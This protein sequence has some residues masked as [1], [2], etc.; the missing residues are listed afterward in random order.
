MCK[1]TQGDHPV[2]RRRAA[3]APPPWCEAPRRAVYFD[4]DGSVRACCAAR[5]AIGSVDEPQR[6]SL[7]AIWSGDEAR[8]LREAVQIGD[9][10]LGCEECG[11][12]AGTLGRSATLAHHFDRWDGPVGGAPVDLEFA[13][14]NTCNLRC[15]MCN[16]FLSSSIR[17]QREHLPPLPSAYDDRFFDELTPWLATARR[18]AF[19]GGEPF[20]ATEA[21]RVMDLLL[22]LGTEAEV[23]VTTNGTQ[24]SDRIERYVTGLRMSPII[25]VDAMDRS[26]LEAIRVGVDAEVLWRNIDRFEAAARSVGERITFSYCLMR[27]NWQELAPLLVEAERR[28]AYVHVSYVHQPSTAA[29]ARLSA[30]ELQRV[31]AGM[32]DQEASLHLAD[33]D[34]RRTWD[35]ARAW[36]RGCAAAP[37]FPPEVDP[38][39]GTA[40]AEAVPVAISPRPPIVA[41]VQ[42]TPTVPEHELD[43]L[44]RWSAGSVVLVW[45]ESGTIERAEVPPW[46]G[47][48]GPSLFVGRSTLD[49]AE[50]FAG[51]VG[52]V[53]TPDVVTDFS[54]VTRARLADE[55]GR[56]LI[57]ALGVQRWEREELHIGL[58]PSFRDEFERRSASA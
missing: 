22:E 19:K 17:A 39:A 10:S 23:K 43:E 42:D 53:L 33:P 57:Q 48:D 51:L 36:V 38:A 2:S 56:E 15:V 49:L 58:H 6:R 50:M 4:V 27:D 3:E 24:W 34:L 54:G 44:H 25:S 37:V 41:V 26:L 52:L 21:R 30:D 18:V 32:D 11:V 8:R 40:R 47:A 35:L 7:D 28:G 14:S 5:R 20:L 55:E 12:T 31:T 46:L 45:A 16:G 9:L 29:L 1:G 13:L